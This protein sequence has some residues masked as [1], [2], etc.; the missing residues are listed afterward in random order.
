LK[1]SV[2]HTWHAPVGT[3]PG[4]IYLGPEVDL[5]AMHVALS[6]GPLFRVAGQGGSAVLFSFGI[7]VRF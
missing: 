1:L 6:L 2:A 4:L 7:G 3:E 5:S